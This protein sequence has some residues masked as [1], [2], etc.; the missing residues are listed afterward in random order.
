VWDILRDRIYGLRPSGHWVVLDCGANIGVSTRIYALQNRYGR[1]I[2]IEPNPE[3]LPKLIRN[4]GD[5]DY[6]LCE[7]KRWRYY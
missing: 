1:V 7:T 3:V 2:A 6:G 5:L 4:T